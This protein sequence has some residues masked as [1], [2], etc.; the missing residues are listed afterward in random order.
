LLKHLQGL[1]TAALPQQRVT[2]IRIRVHPIRIGL[3][4]AEVLDAMENNGWQ[5]GCAAQQ[6]GVSRPSLYKL[7]EAHPAIRPAALIPPDEVKAA[8]RA[9]SADLGQCASQLK[10]PSE[11][12]RRHLRVLGLD[13]AG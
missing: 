11:A 5:I 3:S 1:V 13:G 6:L 2:Q 9:A 7:I 4:E 10:T 8:W 12:L